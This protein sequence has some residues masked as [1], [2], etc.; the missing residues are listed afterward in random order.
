MVNH[1]KNHSDRE[2]K[3]KCFHCKQWICTDCQVQLGH[4]VFCSVRCFTLHYFTRLWQ[5]IKNVPQ[6]L[7]KQYAS[8]RPR[9]TLRTILEFFLFLLVMVSIIM[10]IQNKQEL[11]E[12]K[13]GLVEKEREVDQP[14][15]VTVEDKDTLMISYPPSGSMV[16]KNTIDIEGETESNCIVSLSSNGRLVDAQV[17]KSKK[18]EFKNVVGKPGQNRFT[19]KAFREDGVSYLLEEIL[20]TFGTP[21]MTYLSRD[22]TR[23]DISE[24]KMSF[25]FD[26]GYLNNA[27]GE[28]L[29]ILK[30]ENVRATM[31]LTG[32]FLRNYPDLVKRMVEDGHE[33]GN[34]TWTHP[35]LTTF[36]KN[37][38]HTT[39]D[40]V[41][42][43]K[44]QE[45]LL[46]TSQ[47]FKKITGKEM[48]RLW[49]A[50]YGEHNA[51]IRQWA[52]EV[53][54][55]HIG[56]TL[57]RRWED[58]MDTLDWVADKNSVAYHSAD[59]ITEKIL[60]FGKAYESGA[61]GAVVLMHLGTERTDDYP[62]LQLPYIIE[63]LRKMD[64]QIVTIPE[65][66][67]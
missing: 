57:G 20:L 13:S 66:L 37:R 29:D 41:T 15:E 65:M 6:H 60:S 26:G 3:R 40:G 51:E 4:H 22:F 58:G 5:L 17:V 55:R 23:G 64:Y 45:E 50:P 28:I 31:F 59:E 35:H 46:R 54:F 30:Q 2:A 11:S 44:V 12:I 42:R 18:F 62:H 63:Q 52:A 34:H 10:M 48:A 33:V 27:T 8:I 19:I 61:N 16:L 53:G 24:R 7:K 32:I 1:C 67:D 49:R 9:L 56:W 43:E 21:T 25:T 39:L 38:K 47:L 14:V 36:A